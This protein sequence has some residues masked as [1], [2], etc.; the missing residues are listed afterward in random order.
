MNR[1]FPHWSVIYI[2]LRVL[3]FTCTIF[4]STGICAQEDSS[5]VS[6]LEMDE[7]CTA[8]FFERS[9]KIEDPAK[10]TIVNKA[11]RLVTMS[12]FMEKENMGGFAEYGLV[13]LDNDG[14]NELVISNFTGGAH[15]CDEI[16]VFRNIAPRKYQ[17]VVKMYGGDVCITRE[18]IFH[19][20]FYQ[21]LGYFFT[22]FAC[23]YFDSS[24]T[25]P[26][27]IH[28]ISL[29][30]SKGKLSVIPGTK[31]LRSA[32]NDNL[33]K[34]GEQPYEDIDDIAQDNGLRKEMAMNLATFY[35]SFGRNLVETKAMFNKYYKFPDAA[36]V[37]KEFLIHI[38][39]LKKVNDF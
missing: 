31:D 3:F 21:H 32:I 22:C 11:G 25:A 29:K 35:F 19:Y 24:D 23:A 18:N 13:D 4:L 14:K 30:Y 27:P 12:S 1:I 7:N 39:H 6:A 5:L 2:P 33:A 16:Y 9:E 34:L 26:I 10:I 15:C 37:W 28:S 38:N 8:A 17:W 36:R 20:S